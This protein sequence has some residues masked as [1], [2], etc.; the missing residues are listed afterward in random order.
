MKDILLKGYRDWR[1]CS[2]N[3]INFTLILAIIALVA[4]LTTSIV[5][6]SCGTV[7]K[8]KKFDSET[9]DS[10]YERLLKKHNENGLGKSKDSLSR[11]VDS[12]EFS[13]QALNVSVSLIE[14]ETSQRQDDIRQ[15]TNNIINKFNGYL[16]WWLLLLGI[17]CG[18]A[19]LVLA[20]LNHKND[21]EYIKLLNSNYRE[22]LKKINEKE[23][24]IDEKLKELD[25]LMSDLEKSDKARSKDL[26]ASRKK[27]EL[28][29]TFVYI[30]SFTSKS[31]F[32]IS[33]DRTRLVD[34]LLF[35]LIN[36]SLKCITNEN[37][38]IS[39]EADLLYWIM[40]SIEGLSL[41]APYQTDM[42]KLR[43]INRIIRLL[44]Q[45]QMDFFAGKINI[46]DGATIQTILIEFK[47]FQQAFGYK[48]S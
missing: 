32:Q 36:N 11:R 48:E 41:L 26:Y 47:E 18:F 2:K 30:A 46:R 40:T 14:K 31:Q 10:I 29:H 45:I 5:S 38:Q 21:S 42:L 44:K 39:S 22:T 23:K 8:S 34:K 43:R 24:R 1:C 16:S 3:S 6:C 13:L 19:P 25:D 20:Y 12:L 33:Q 37:S 17:V 7:E 4:I 35:E 28:L 9:I 27:L 15:E